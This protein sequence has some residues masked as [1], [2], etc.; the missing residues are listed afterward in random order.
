MLENATARML[1]KGDSQNNQFHPIMPSATVNGSC[2]E[3]VM[4]EMRR[5]M[6]PV[7]P[8]AKS[9]FCGSCITDSGLEPKEKEYKGFNGMLCCDG[10]DDAERF[11]SRLL[12]SQNT[13]SY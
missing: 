1:R 13:V 7:S 4:T 10:D 11:P 8:T 5:P 12:K 6:I 2:V 3:P 9:S